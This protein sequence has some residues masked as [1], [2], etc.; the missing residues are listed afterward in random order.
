MRINID[1]ERKEIE[2]SGP[3][4]LSELTVWCEGNL[5]GWE[6]YDIAFSQPPADI[7]SPYIPTTEPNPPYWETFPTITCKTS[8]TGTNSNQN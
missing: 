2:I 1:T 5:Y 3:V 6:E 4:K 7:P 8:T